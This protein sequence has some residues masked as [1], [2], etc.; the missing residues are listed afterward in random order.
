MAR[1][2]AGVWGVR[3]D[4]KWTPRSGNGGFSLLAKSRTSL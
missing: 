1:Y 4:A 3:T 2:L